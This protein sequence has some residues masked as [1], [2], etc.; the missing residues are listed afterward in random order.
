MSHGPRTRRRIA[1]FVV[2]VVVVVLCLRAGTRALANTGRA[3]ECFLGAYE[4]GERIGARPWQGLATDKQ[5]FHRM[6]KRTKCG[7]LG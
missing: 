4:W 6:E 7:A 5:A 3:L 2:V 1:L